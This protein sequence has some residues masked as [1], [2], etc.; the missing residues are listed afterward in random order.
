M[1]RG[2][3]HGFPPCA[4][5]FREADSSSLRSV[6]CQAPLRAGAQQEPPA[7]PGRS[8]PLGTNQPSSRDLSDVPSQGGHHP[9]PAVLRLPGSGI[10]S[11]PPCSCCPVFPVEPTFP[12]QCWVQPVGFQPRVLSCLSPD[13]GTCSIP[14]FNKSSVHPGPVLK[15]ECGTLPSHNP[16]VCSAAS[17]HPTFAALLFKLWRC[18]ERCSGRWEKCDLEVDAPES[19]G[20]DSLW[21][22]R[23]P[24]SQEPPS[25]WV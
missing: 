2:A 23:A 11:S 16:V 25:P 18:S 6:Q 13:P 19:K 10:P 20:L 22:F 1:P 5:L 9:N 12:L 21:P 4:H 14:G 3:W 8:H 15:L 17:S 7:L 24:S